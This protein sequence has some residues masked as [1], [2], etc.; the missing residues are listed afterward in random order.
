MNTFKVFDFF[1]KINWLV[2]KIYIIQLNGERI[3]PVKRI[4]HTGVACD[5]IINFPCVGSPCEQNTRV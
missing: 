2:I 5:F 3:I 1:P 4:A